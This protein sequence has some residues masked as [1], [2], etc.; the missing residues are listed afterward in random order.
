MSAINKQMN[1]L[2]GVPTPV[3][4]KDWK[5]YNPES[6]SDSTNPFAGGLE[7]AASEYDRSDAMRLAATLGVTDTI[8]GVKQISGF[9]KVDMAVDQKLLNKL[10]EHPEW[11]GDIKWTYFGSLLLDP[12]GWLTPASKVA[13]L[14]KA[15]YK[16]T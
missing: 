9:D 7:K 6:T 1:S 14:A 10:M 2:I 15:G 5:P 8:R 13:Q 3:N 4:A 11:G 12:I 16:F